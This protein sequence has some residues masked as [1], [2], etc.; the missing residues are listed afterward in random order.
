MSKPRLIAIVG[1]TA[2]GKSALALELAEKLG[3]EIVSADSMQVYRGMDIGTAKPSR[4]EQQRV[5]HHLI[6]I[7]EPNETYS[8]GRYQ[9]DACRAIASVHERGTVP[10]LTGGSGLYVN[11]ITHNLDLSARQEPDPALRRELGELGGEEL[12]LRLQQ[13]DAQ[14]AARIHPHNIV[15]VRRALEIALSSPEVPYDFDR[16]DTPY[17]LRIAAI[18]RPREELY[19]RINRRVDQMMEQGLAAEVEGLYRRF[20]SGGSALQA[21]GYKE[22]IAYLEGRL[23]SLGEAADLIKLNTRHF[24]KRQLTWFRRDPRIVW[25]GSPQEQEAWISEVLE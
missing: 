20:G 25:L 21:I 7:A 22:I 2:S 18:S 1:P 14:A 15:R 10:I 11:S 12:Y 23:G 24:A 19:E 6:D 8:V 17:D 16:W 9:A 4:E 5:P 3:G 13:E